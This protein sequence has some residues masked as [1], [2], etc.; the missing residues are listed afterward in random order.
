[1]GDGNKNRHGLTISTES[2]P[3]NDTVRLLNVLMV[4]YRLDCTMRKHSPRYT[5]YIKEKSMSLLRT[6]VQPHMHSS[7]LYKLRINTYENILL[8]LIYLKTFPRK[9]KS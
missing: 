2:F 5:I 1:M 6:L 9:G 8:K 7:M 4:R 3:L